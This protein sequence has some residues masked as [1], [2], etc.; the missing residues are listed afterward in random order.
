MQKQEF[1]NWATSRLRA[2]GIELATSQAEQIFSF[3]LEGADAELSGDSLERAKEIVNRRQKREPLEYILGVCEFAGRTFTVL[4]G[5]HSPAPDT[6]VVVEVALDAMHGVDSP[7]LIDTGTGV[8]VI[9]I[10]LALELPGASGCLGDVSEDAVRAAALNIDRHGLTGRMV[11]TQSDILKGFP[12]TE[13]GLDLIVANLPYLPTGVIAKVE[14]HTPEFK[15]K[16]RVGMD[17]GMD[18]LVL[19][20][21]LI[22][23]AKPRLRPGGTLVMKVGNT[24]FLEEMNVIVRNDLEKAGYANARVHQGKKPEYKAHSGGATLGETIRVV[25]ATWNGVAPG[26]RVDCERN[27]KESS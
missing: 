22:E 1:I 20:R 27:E 8:G 25:S 6:E 26:P 9:G 24:R 7:R 10:C 5:A 15:H 14:E 21:R 12:D 11:A 4:P 16:P 18:G 3:V 13:T 23:E 2:S 19:V 17:G